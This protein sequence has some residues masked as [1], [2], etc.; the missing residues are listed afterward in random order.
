MEAGTDGAVWRCPV[1]T[2]ADGGVA[3]E[4]RAEVMRECRTDVEECLS[5]ANLNQV[6]SPG[7]EGCATAAGD[8]CVSAIWRDSQERWYAGCRED[9]PPVCPV[10]TDIFGAP[11]GPLQECD[12]AASAAGC[13]AGA[14]FRAQ[15]ELPYVFTEPVAP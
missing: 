7:R 6:F 12:L 11:V 1:E 2:D 9:D 14:P 15:G 13:V 10:A 3:K 5:A 4:Q 8:S